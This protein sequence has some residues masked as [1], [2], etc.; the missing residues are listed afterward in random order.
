MSDAKQGDG[1]ATGKRNVASEN[2]LGAIAK[3]KR[4]KG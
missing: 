3:L 1:Y 2:V 4:M